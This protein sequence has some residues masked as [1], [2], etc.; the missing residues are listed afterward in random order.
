MPW[1]AV[2]AAFDA[3]Q[4]KQDGHLSTEGISTKNAECCGWVYGKM[5]VVNHPQRPVS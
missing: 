1:W 5:D 3:L 2:R 4:T